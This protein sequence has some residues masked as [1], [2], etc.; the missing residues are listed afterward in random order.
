M[1]LTRILSQIAGT[2]CLI[3]GGLALVIA[4]A[5]AYDLCT[6]GPADYSESERATCQSQV[7]DGIGMAIRTWAMD[8]HGQYPFNVSTNEGGT[9]ELCAQGRD[10]F[11][12]NAWLHFR[13]LSNELA[14]PA[15]L[16]CPRDRKH[17]PARDFQ[18]LGPENVT[19]RLR[20]GTNLTED[21]TKDVLVVCPLGGIEVYCD[22]HWGVTAPPAADGWR[23]ATSF[24]QGVGQILI[25]L[26]AA[27]LFAG[28]GSHLK[29]KRG[30]GA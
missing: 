30:G 27:A 23:Y 1:R 24:R 29:S 14:D 15:F 21:N 9:R 18:S 16:V 7:T 25:S 13:V 22:G 4:V 20:T 8:H 17:K 11:D 12:R 2:L 26:G 28:L 10:G 6:H 5:F 3:A 19:Y